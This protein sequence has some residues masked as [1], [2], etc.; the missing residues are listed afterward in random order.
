[1]TM[2][3]INICIPMQ[4]YK[5]VCAA[6]MICAIVVNT[7]THRQLLTGSILLA[8]PALIKT[9]QQKISKTQKMHAVY[10]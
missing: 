10:Y 1:M 3:A 4:D 9:A 5:F 8:Q 7:Q 2:G 6:V